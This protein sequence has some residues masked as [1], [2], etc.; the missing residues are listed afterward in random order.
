MGIGHDPAEG[1]VSWLNGWHGASAPAEF[2]RPLDRGCCCGTDHQRRCTFAQADLISL[3]LP[4]TPILNDTDTIGNIKD[5]V[6]NILE[7]HFP[8]KN[9]SEE[10]SPIVSNLDEYVK[11]EKPELEGS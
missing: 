6:Q 8:L 7:Y 3:K 11:L 2:L 1:L 4:F 10:I 5:I 9:Y